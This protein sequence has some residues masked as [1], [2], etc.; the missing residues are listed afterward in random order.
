MSD[1]DILFMTSRQLRLGRCHRRSECKKL[2]LKLI[3][4]SGLGRFISSKEIFPSIRFYVSSAIRIYKRG[5]I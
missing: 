5:N 1:G 2:E 3:V 4:T